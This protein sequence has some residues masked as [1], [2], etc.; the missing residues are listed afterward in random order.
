MKF[1]EGKGIIMNIKKLI[2]TLT[3]SVLICGSFVSCSDEKEEAAPV[4]AITPNPGDA[5]LSIFD[6][7][8][9]GRYLGE[10]TDPLAY[11]AGVVH[12]DGNGEYTVSVNADTDEFRYS[13]TKNKDG[14]YTEYGVSFMSVIIKDG[15]TECPDAIIT[16]NSVKAD[17]KEIELKK[18]SYTNS[19]GGSIR[20]NIYNSFV[21]STLPKDARTAEGY[22]FLDR[23]RDTPNP[24]ID[25][26]K[27]SPEIVDASDFGEW[28]KIEVTFTVSGM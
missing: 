26:S 5:Y 8:S 24:D 9:Q 1:F 10:E 20:S 14:Q 13:M 6:A 4:K 22:I 11:D 25:A 3:A 7:E 15:D 23:N 18:Q 27:Y 21:G 17:G 28:T 19:E 16:V 12:I 2:M